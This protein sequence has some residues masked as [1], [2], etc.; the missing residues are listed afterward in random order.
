MR[1]DTCKRETPVVMRV[2]VAKGYNRALAKP[3]FNCPDCFERKEDTKRARAQQEKARSA[4]VK[5]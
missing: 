2:V 1:C 3:L 4:D 5:P